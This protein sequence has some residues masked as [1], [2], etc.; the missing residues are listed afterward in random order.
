MI[1]HIQIVNF[2]YSLDLLNINNVLMVAFT[3]GKSFP[4][5]DKANGTEYCRAD[6]TDSFFDICYY[7]PFVDER[8]IKAWGKD[9][10][11][12]GVFEAHDIPFFLV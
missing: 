8:H 12:Y 2:N 11:K 4:L 7:F 10:F 9:S 6:L 5:H 3:F 1:N